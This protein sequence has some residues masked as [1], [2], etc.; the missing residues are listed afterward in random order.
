MLMGV[1]FIASGM[2]K[3]IAQSDFGKIIYSYNMV[4]K[5]WVIMLSFIIPYSELILGTMLI[6]NLYPRIAG[7]LL[8]GMLLIFTGVSGHSIFF[9]KF[10]PAKQIYSTEEYIFN[11]KYLSIVK[12]I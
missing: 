5:E 3:I 9:S 1:V 4:S 2:S 10:D 11:E 12:A 8:T 6:L 7:A